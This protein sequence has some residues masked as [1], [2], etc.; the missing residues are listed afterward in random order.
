M[1]PPM[2]YSCVSLPEIRRLQGFLLLLLQIWS[3]PHPGK[4]LAS[5]QLHVPLCLLTPSLLQTKG[6]TFRLVLHEAQTRANRFG[7][8]S[9]FW[10]S[11]LGV[12]VE[13]GGL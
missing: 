10:E 1:R 11:Q 2:T 7:K 8:T 4:S 5:Y 13:R 9:T 3:L 12:V 6:K